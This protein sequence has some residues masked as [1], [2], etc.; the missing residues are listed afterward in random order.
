MKGFLDFVIVCMWILSTI[1]GFGYS[2]Y[3]E[4]WLIAIAVLVNGVL[5]FPTVKKA[6][7][8]SLK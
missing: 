1:G 5:A 4:A 3:C 8:E 7:D 2:L 6:Y